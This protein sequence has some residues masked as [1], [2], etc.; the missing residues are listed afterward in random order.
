MK[1]SGKVLSLLMAVLLTVSCSVGLSA[2][3]KEAASAYELVLITD[4]A[5]INDKGYNQSAWNGVKA[6]GDENNIAY[7]YYQ[8]SL[9]EA[10]ELTTETIA[11][12]IDLAA[13]GGAKT[14]VL[15]GEAFAVAA[16]EVAATFQ[17]INFILVDAYPHAAGD[18]VTHFVPNVMCVTFDKLAAGYLAGYFSVSDGLKNA[19]GTAARDFNTRLGYLGSMSSTAAVQYGTGFV[20]GAAAAADENSVPVILDYAEYDNPLLAYNYSFTVRPVYI[21]REEADK[22]TFKVNVV[23][24]LGSGVYTEGENVTVS[25]EPAPEGKVFDHWEVK[26]DTAG[27]KD[28]KVNI[29]HKKRATMNLLVGD[30]DCTITAVYA[31]ASTVPVTVTAEDGITPYQVYNVQPDTIAFVT[32]PPAAS[33]MVFDHWETNDEAAVESLTEKGTNVHVSNNAVTLMPVYAESEVPVFTVTVENGTGSGAYLTDEEITVVADPPQ[34]GMMFYKWENVDANGNSAGIAMDNE[35]NYATTFKM[36]NRVAGIAE[37][38]YDSGTQI[39]FGGGNPLSDSIFTATWSF[40]Y[41]VYAYGSGIDESSKGNCFASVVNDYG[42]AVKLCLESFAGAS[43]LTGN[44]ANGC[45]YITGKSVNKYQLDGNGNVVQDKEGN[46]VEDAAYS[47][48]YQTVYNGLAD[49]TIRPQVVPS[50]AQLLSK[51]DTD[52]L[53]VNYWITVPTAE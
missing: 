33:G 41:P 47:E 34:D 40:D 27:V 35:Y 50:A 44:C 1:L 5:P 51:L 4:G 37:E 6:Y 30:C 13:K 45:I 8:P 39:I 43:I 31:D 10:G 24:G 23:G 25:A 18:S 11:T 12:Y 3:G 16:Y 15:P 53:T 48:A 14:V 46:S 19:D 9:N 2:C 49:G 29:S 38:M 7:R 28:K 20:Q 21:P 26:S 52:C 17:D 22:E 32:A 36:V 42:A